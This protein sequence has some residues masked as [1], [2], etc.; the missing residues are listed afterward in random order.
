MNSDPLSCSPALNLNSYEADVVT[1]WG[2]IQPVSF[3]D[4]C[5]P[6]PDASKP[7]GRVTN[8]L[9]KLHLHHPQRSPVTDESSLAV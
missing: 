2:L 4:H 5:T 9:R 8:F 3:G 1:V 6:L 7:E